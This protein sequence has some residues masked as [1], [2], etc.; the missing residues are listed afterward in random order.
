M[1][2]EVCDRED[3][4]G[5]VGVSELLGARRFVPVEDRLEVLLR[6]ARAAAKAV[7]LAE[8]GEAERSRGSERREIRD[9]EAVVHRVGAA[10]VDRVE[11]RDVVVDEDGIAE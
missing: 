10:A 5:A 4:A 6:A 2:A 7:L 9:A 1:V 8:L 11:D 3:A